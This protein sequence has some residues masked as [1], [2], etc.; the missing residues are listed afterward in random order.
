MLVFFLFANSADAQF[1][2]GVERRPIREDS[3]R[4]VDSSTNGETTIF[5]PKREA[6]LKNDVA[7]GGTLGT[8]GGLNFV[9]E[10]YYDRVGLR[11]EGGAILIIFEVVAGWQADLSYV[12][13]QRSDYLVECSA[14]YFQGVSMGP[15]D[16]ETRYKGFGVGMGLT[17]GPVFLQLG[18]GHTS[19]ENQYTGVNPN[20]KLINGMPMSGQ[21]GLIIPLHL[22]E[23]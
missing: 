18:I 20:K 3:L 9:A 19:S 5:T 6:F 22:A 16:G 21:V 1:R 23:W 4:N 7:L 17:A 13:A 10:G 11:I 2:P 12:L 8:P 14:I 15:D